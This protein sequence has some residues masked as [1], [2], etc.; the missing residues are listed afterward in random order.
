[1]KLGKCDAGAKRG[2]RVTRICIYVFIFAF[3]CL[4][5]YLHLDLCIYIS[6]SPALTYNEHDLGVE[7]APRERHVFCICDTNLRP[8]ETF[9]FEFVTNFCSSAC[10]DCA[11]NFASE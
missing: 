6:H 8:R 3:S 1:M 4:Y 10:T 7:E 11:R 2:M 5:L 9:E